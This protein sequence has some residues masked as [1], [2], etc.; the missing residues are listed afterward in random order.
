[1]LLEVKEHFCPY[2]A[3]MWNETFFSLVLLGFF[4]ECPEPCSAKDFKHNWVRWS[5]CL[6]FTHF[7]HDF[8]RIWKALK[9]SNIFPWYH[10]R[11]ADTTQGTWIMSCFVWEEKENSV[12]L[13]CSLWGIGGG[14]CRWFC[15]S[16]HWYR[17]GGS[18]DYGHSLRKVLGIYMVDTQITP[19]ATSDLV[20]QVNQL[21]RFVSVF[22][23][24]EQDGG[25]V[26]LEPLIFSFSK[27]IRY[28]IWSTRYLQH[29]EFRPDKAKALPKF[30]GIFPFMR[31]WF[32]LV[33]F[34]HWLGSGKRW[35]EKKHAIQICWSLT[36]NETL[37][38][39][40][41]ALSLQSPDSHFPCQSINCFMLLV[42]DPSCIDHGLCTLLCFSHLNNWCLRQR[43][44][45]SA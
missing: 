24:G 17:I 32:Q 7:K 26:P 10:F 6:N 5:Q 35:N 40:Q 12:M 2:I 19:V 41:L 34:L 33:Q 25:Y 43:L 36:V 42:P 30:Q 16:G 39:S 20:L 38:I 11:A 9:G 22:S 23:V 3:I 21:I 8:S 14:G 18:S 4:L 31:W 28:T 15:H 45:Q 27:D 29:F 13:V 1:M 44:V 37:N